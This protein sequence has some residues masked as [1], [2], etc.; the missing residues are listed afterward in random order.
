MSESQEHVERIAAAAGR[1][2]IRV[3]VAESLT[4]GLVASRLGAGPDAS[5]W[6][7]GGITAYLPEVKYDVLG[8]PRG[9]LVS[10]PCAEQMARGTAD[11]FG[12]DA[13]LALTGVGGPDPEEDEPP[14]TVYLAILLGDLLEVRRLDLAGDDPEAILHRTADRALEL[15]G[16]LLDDP[17]P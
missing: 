2:G 17:H 10:I 9:P 4:S 14:G 8:V 7:A 15:L 3:A 12:S 13:T 11:L 1:R 16:E 6:F 5:E